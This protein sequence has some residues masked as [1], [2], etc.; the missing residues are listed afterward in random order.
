M[1]QN[2][3][4]LYFEICSDVQMQLIWITYDASYKTVV[5]VA[6]TLHETHHCKVFYSEILHVLAS[7]EAQLPQKLLINSVKLCK[8]HVNLHLLYFLLNCHLIKYG[9]VQKSEDHTLKV[10]TFLTLSCEMIFMYIFN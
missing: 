2:S 10:C 1:V 4:V 9:E 7:L 3:K 5:T 6:Y 8:L